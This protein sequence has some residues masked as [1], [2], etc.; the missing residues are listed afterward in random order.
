MGSNPGVQMDSQDL[1]RWEWE[2]GML[3]RP[4]GAAMRSPSRREASSRRPLTNVLVATD[5]SSGAELAVTRALRLPRAATTKLSFLHVVAGRTDSAA[6]REEETMLAQHLEEARRLATRAAGSAVADGA[7]ARSMARGKASRE[8]VRAA[9]KEQSEII[10]LGRHGKSAAAATRLGSTVEAVIRKA[11]TSVLMV[12]QP[13]YGPYQRPLVAVD[14]SETSPLVIDLALRLTDADTST[15]DVLHVLGAR[16]A[17]LPRDRVGKDDEPEARTQLE[18]FLTAFAGAGVEF[19]T[20][21]GRG[22]PRDV[23]VDAAATRGCDLIV[24][25]A[26]DRASLDRFLIGSV[27]EAIVRTALCDVLVVRPTAD[28]VR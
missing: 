28:S 26:Q 24:L 11:A 6:A 15:I 8:I 19:T 27:A 23:I 20:V 16:E 9:R 18:T 7:I 22:D 21:I 14:F 3:L 2:G 5:L 12:S 10:V 17:G 13:V 1:A 4:A 25:G